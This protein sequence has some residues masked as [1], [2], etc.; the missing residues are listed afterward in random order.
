MRI[1]LSWHLQPTAT[2]RHLWP[3]RCL[4]SRLLPL[5]TESSL[6]GPR[7]HVRRAVEQVLQGVVPQDVCLLVP[8]AV[9]RP[10]DGSVKLVNVGIRRTFASVRLDSRWARSEMAIVGIVSLPNLS[11]E[12]R[13]EEGLAAKVTRYVHASVQAIRAGQPWW[14]WQPEGLSLTIENADIAL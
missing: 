6:P 7:P 9:F 4:H 3:C 12:A 1:S 10:A 8:R 11:L 13:P 2:L 14:R 5:D